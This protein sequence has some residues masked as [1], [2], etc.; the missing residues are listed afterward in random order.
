MDPYICAGIVIFITFGLGALLVY[1]IYL[2]RTQT[3]D[4][5]GLT[6]AVGEFLPDM[7]EGVELTEVF[8]QL[9]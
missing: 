1:K 4:L 3:P 7:P 5:S 8:D 6:D 9:K 2:D